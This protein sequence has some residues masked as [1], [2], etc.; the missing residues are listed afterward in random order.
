MRKIAINT[1]YGGFGLSQEATKMLYELQNPGKQLYAYKK[2]HG[3]LFDEPDWFVKSTVEDSSVFFTKDLG[4]KVD[5]SKVNNNLFIFE[6]MLT[7]NRHDP[8]LIK[9]IETLGTRANGECAAIKIVEIPDD[10]K[11][12]I[13]EYD[14]CETVV[15]RDDVDNWDW[16]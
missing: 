6:W 5:A 7:D 3:N 9:V 16:K 15:T 4:D 10:T 11:Y 1:D 14:G 8:N 13:Q 2:V 12:I